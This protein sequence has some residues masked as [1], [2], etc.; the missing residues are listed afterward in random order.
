MR[1]VWQGRFPAMRPPALLAEEGH[2]L[3][4]RGGPVAAGLRG[5]C[6]LRCTVPDASGLTLL[7]P[8]PV[9]PGRARG[10]ARS[11]WANVIDAVLEQ[12]RSQLAGLEAAPGPAAA[13]SCPPA[14]GFAAPPAHALKGSARREASLAGW[15]RRRVSGSFGRSGSAA[16]SI[17]AAI[18]SAIDAVIQ[19]KAALP[20]PPL[21]AGSD[22]DGGAAAAA[23][24]L[25]SGGAKAHMH[26]SPLRAA[27]LAASISQGRGLAAA[28]G[29]GREPAAPPPKQ[30]LSRVDL[31]R[32]GFSFNSAGSSMALA[33]FPE[34]TQGRM[35]QASCGV[36]RAGQVIAR[37]EFVW[38]FGHWECGAYPAASVAGML[39]FPSLPCPT[40][41]A[42]LLLLHVP[43]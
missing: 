7:G 25:P 42:S 11:S 21:T 41:A 43:L 35:A 37:R 22:S 40:P 4:A 29:G 9:V 31:L 33:L 1:C 15:L 10:R 8:A 12:Q 23:A 26:S 6:L 5:A 16:S 14:L 19:E 38:R 17:D 24:S 3:L 28:A 36:V 13:E 30:A 2:C 32:S 39:T 34:T 20:P 27:S 18:E